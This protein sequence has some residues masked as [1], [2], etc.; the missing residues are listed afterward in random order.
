MEDRG[1]QEEY[2]RQVLE[3]Y[4]RTPGTQGTVRRAD[5]TLAAQ[6]YQRGLSAR[7]IE[8]ALVLAARAA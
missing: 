5:R 2:V 7:V 4:R 1:G 3:A 8:N 6:L